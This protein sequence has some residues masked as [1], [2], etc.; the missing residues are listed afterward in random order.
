M[1]RCFARHS[2]RGNP[3]AR[4]LLLGELVDAPIPPEAQRIRL[5]HADAATFLEQEPAGCFDGFSLSN[6]LDGASD[7]YRRRLL[8]AVH[9][10][11]APG[12][13][14]VIRSVAEPPQRILDESRP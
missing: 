13:V 14:A 12:A 9:R 8:A 3:Y 6:I 11:A 7:D 2:N 1:E 4:A 10:A 5:V